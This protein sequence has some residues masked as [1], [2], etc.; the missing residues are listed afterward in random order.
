MALDDWE[1]K[2]MMADKDRLQLKMQDN[3]NQMHADA[4]QS[5][6]E[7][8]MQG[9]RNFMESNPN[10]VSNFERNAVLGR[11][12]QLEDRRALRDHE[13]KMLD[14]QNE[15]ALEIQQEKTRGMIEQGATA[16]SAKAAADKT[17][18]DN[19][20]AGKRYEVDA[21]KVIELDRNK[22][23]L[24]AEEKKL[25]GALEVEKERQAGA[26]DVAKQ[27]G[28]DALAVQKEKSVGEA[29]NVQAQVLAQNRL[30]EQQQKIQS[31]KNDAAI[32]KAFAELKI[33]NPRMTDEELWSMLAAR[34][35]E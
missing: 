9:R 20:L 34:Q 13:M 7:R 5:A 33:A 26:L 32:R 6:H 35:G 27:Q 30:F 21:N 11:A 8:F 17:V 15:G 29:N 25:A 18:S 14:K 4:V 22:T 1:K 3:R 2:S 28:A 31:M 23:T 12:Q 19:L 24:T 16:A 10:A